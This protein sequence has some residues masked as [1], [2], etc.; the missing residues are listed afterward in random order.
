MTRGRLLQLANLAFW[1]VVAAAGVGFV[2]PKWRQFDLSS[3]LSEID[4]TWLIVASLLLVFQYLLIFHLWRRVLKLLH[5][6]VPAGLLYRAFGLSLLP[7][8]LPGKVLGAGLRAGLTASA[9]VPYPV[10]VG[11][12]FWE[13]GLSLSA[14]VAITA[15]GIIGGVSQDLDPTAH[16]LALAILGAAAAGLVAST[17]PR[18][19]SVVGAWLHVGI[20]WKRPAAVAALFLGYVGAW[21]VYGLAHWMLARAIGPFP[22]GKALPLLV[23]L[24][25]SWALG[26]LSLLAPGGLGVREGALFLFARGSMGTSTALLF[27]TLSRLLLFLVEVL[28][29]VAAWASGPRRQVTARSTSD[30]GRP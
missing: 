8:Y 5:G 9:G 6:F 7:K 13:I 16:G 28:L 14:A 19:R 17:V 30:S 25:T 15:L 1:I 18:I 26:V 24:A 3:R 21:L 20:A 12:L 10:A 2:A 23:A 11:S 22:S 29:T 27:V 4:F